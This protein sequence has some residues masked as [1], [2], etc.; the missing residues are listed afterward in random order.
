MEEFLRSCREPALLEPGEDL[1]PLTSDSFSLE[2]R[3]SRLTFQAWDRTRNV[4]RRI[5]AAEVAAAGR[6]ELTV[7]HF[8]KR[9]GQAFLLD[10]AARSGAELG[11]RSGRLIFRERFRM[12]LRR[13][14][15]GWNLAE[16]SAEQNLEYSLSSSYARAFLRHGQH[17]WAAIACPPEADATG[18]LTFGLIWLTHLRARE[19]RTTVEG[20][21]I[22]TPEGMERTTALRLRHLDA[23]A[24]RFAL[25][26]YTPGDHVA[27][28]DAQDCGN[29]DTRL[30]TCRRAP[31]NHEHAWSKITAHPAVESI[32]RHD[33]RVSLRVRGVEFAVLE[34]RE[35]LFGLNHS[36]KRQP[37]GERHLP[38]MARLIEE[39]DRVRSPQ[40]EMRD[41]PL[42]R[43]Y[44]EAWLESQARAQIE[45]I[46]AS[47]LR[48]PVY[49][50]VPAFAGGERGVLDLLG[51]DYGGRLAVVELKTSADIHLPLQAL[52][53]WLRV[54]WHLKRGEFAA[55]GY[56][57][58][59]ELRT[60]A[61]RLV[62]ACPSLEFH[63]TT[64]TILEY[65]AP[66]IEVERVGLALE[67][68]KGLETVF[69]LR[70][71]ERPR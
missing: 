17:G 37:A 58:G 65:F 54:A 6:M 4:T 23:N 35:L 53:Y 60:E 20:L 50:Q 5:V 3:A 19:R 15:P 13:Q 32:A 51:V 38:E 29:L 21:A 45:T 10:L 61:P 63:P 39:L 22:Y 34:G 27:A 52:D 43:Q 28:I 16:L 46:D 11:K 12:L 56:F 42:Y 41:H 40:A 9:Q 8:A 36:A 64:E 59:I 24:A 7:E 49:G 1:F 2:V 33:G 47:L 30:E 25:F 62:L 26:T 31:P 48:N 55:N 68:R 66:E 57:P 70:G 67:W 69:R 18:V 44:P 14:F 71:A